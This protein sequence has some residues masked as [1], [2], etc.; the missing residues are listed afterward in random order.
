MQAICCVGDCLSQGVD[1]FPVLRIGSDR[2]PLQLEDARCAR[3]QSDLRVLEE[4]ADHRKPRY[5]V[6]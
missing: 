1:E 2:C 6:A 4:L 3:Y 5:V